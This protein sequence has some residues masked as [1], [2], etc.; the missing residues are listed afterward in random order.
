MLLLLLW[1][2]AM[3]TGVLPMTPVHRLCVVW[4]VKKKS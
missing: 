1:V 2:V 3:L 4:Q